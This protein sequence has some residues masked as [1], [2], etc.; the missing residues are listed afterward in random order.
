MRRKAKQFWSGLMGSFPGAMQ[1]SMQQKY[2]QDLIKQRKEAAEAQE[3]RAKRQEETRAQEKSEERRTERG[4]AHKEAA[5]KRRSYQT[6][7]NLLGMEYG[8][9]ATGLIERFKEL[10]P[11]QEVTAG[12]SAPLPGIMG[13]GAQMQVPRI[14]EPD[15]SGMENLSGIL[16]RQQET[17]QATEEAGAL[18]TNEQQAF[19]MLQTKYPEVYGGQQFNPRAAER[20]QYTQSLKELSVAEARPQS[21]AGDWLAQLLGIGPA[22]GGGGGGGVPDIDNTGGAGLTAVEIQQAKM[23][24][25]DLT[26]PNAQRER[27]KMA[28]YN[29]AQIKVILQR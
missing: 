4:R 1:A 26:D 17:A 20:G 18:T 16:R 13:A 12:V 15:I 5:A 11:E 6:I 10:A 24:V 27:L 23:M 25:S 3:E 7:E 22:G 8:E 19:T 14:T 28:G 2:R 9:E 29:D 21:S